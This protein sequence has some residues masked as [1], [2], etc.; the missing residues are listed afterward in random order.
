MTTS[1][2]PISPGAMIWPVFV[3]SLPGCEARRAPLLDALA[4]QGIACEV[5]LGVDG[6]NGLPPEHEPA[7]D[8]AAAQARLRRPISDA[9]LA[10]ALSHQKIYQLIID[11][12][13][14]GAV[15]LED[16]AQPQP[17]FR[18][19][20]NSGAHVRHHLTC[21]DY[22][23]NARALL[24]PGRE[25]LPG[26]VLRRLAAPCHVTTGYAVSARA[27]M[28]LKR[29][30]LPV[31]GVADWPCDITSLGARLVVP[32]LILRP[33][34]REGSMIEPT[35]APLSA[36]RLTGRKDPSRFLTASYWRLRLRRMFSV[37]L[38]PARQS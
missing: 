6:R 31:R 32:R 7:V 33:S 14:P 25:V 9:E 5:V 3:I 1:A 19:F 24:G 16:D 23:D 35:R 28:R 13:L 2:G 11:R 4:A 37:R 12:G 17:G 34:G 20:L 10:C 38:P 29:E 30:G 26:V 36:Q 18:A 15:V 22:A 21:F 27:A 8:R